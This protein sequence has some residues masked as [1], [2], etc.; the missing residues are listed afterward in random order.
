VNNKKL[1]DPDTKEIST[2]RT[3]QHEEYT[4]YDKNG[5]VVKEVEIVKSI[6]KDTKSSVRV[7]AYKYDNME[8]LL[9][10]LTHPV[11]Q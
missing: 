3:S 9:K 10:K 6:G 11:R 2:L 8:D 4:C 5:N 7:Y 1:I